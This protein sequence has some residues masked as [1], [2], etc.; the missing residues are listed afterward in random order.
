ME[1]AELLGIE[2]RAFRYWLQRFE[3]DG[4]AGLL[5][6]RLGKA[7][8]RLVPGVCARI[9]GFPSGKPAQSPHTRTAPRVA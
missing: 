3:D 1:A 7:S 2:E 4:E 9:P 5:D 8:G 6:R